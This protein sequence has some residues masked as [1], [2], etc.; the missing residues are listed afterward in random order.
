VFI[1]SEGFLLSAVAFGAPSSP[2]FLAHGGWVGS[3]ELWQE[4]FQLMD[5]D[6]R[7]I[8]YDHRGAG[9]TTASPAQVT[10]QGLVDDVVRVL[11]FFGVDSCVLAGESLGA[12]TAMSAALQHP[13]RVRGLVL[14]DGVASA[15]T[16]A[17]NPM[18]AACRTDY[19]GTVQWFID[20]CVPEPDSEHLRRWGRQILLRAE[21]EAA[22]RM[23]ESYDEHPV[24]PEAA[25]I[26][27]PT[28]ILH[29][30]LD[31]VVPPAVAHAL[32]DAIPNAELVLIAGA[33]HVPTITR[34]QAV[35]D[36]VN[37]WWR[38]YE[39]GQSSPPAPRS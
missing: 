25:L 3:W 22:A 6:W 10:P 2:V 4:P 5:Q 14:V 21:P 38:A 19:P 7:C 28:L 16:A 32:A 9:V 35:A 17:P 27:Q 20:A 30:E 8:S 36:A 11:D 15:G 31:V 26:G 1:P 33:G 34:P 12:V 18:I 37:T 24:T 13:D 29:G 23:F 39:S